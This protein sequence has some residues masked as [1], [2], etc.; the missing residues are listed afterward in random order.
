LLN[1]DEQTIKEQLRILTGQNLIKEM[2]PGK[3]VRKVLD[4][5]TGIA[6]NN[7]AVT[8]FS[9]KM[10]VSVDCMSKCS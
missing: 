9:G 1:T 4:Q 3:W 5:K 10:L 7:S 2:E 8:E 6:A